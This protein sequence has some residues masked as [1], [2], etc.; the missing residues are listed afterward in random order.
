LLR[1]SK[2]S[3]VVKVEG[4]PEQVR[5]AD[6]QA[7]K[8]VVL[9]FTFGGAPPAETA[10]SPAKNSEEQVPRASPV[11]TPVNPEGTPTNPTNSV[12]QGQSGTTTIQ[13]TPA[14]LETL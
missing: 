9:E 1:P 10:P 13:T 3:V 7:G 11:Q 14:P 12:F 2:Q 4:R 5:T 8:R 6:I